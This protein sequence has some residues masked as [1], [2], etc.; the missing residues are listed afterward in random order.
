MAFVEAEQTNGSKEDVDD[1]DMFGEDDE[2]SRPKK[3]RKGVYY[4]PIGMRALLR[5]IRANVSLL[6]A[7]YLRLTVSAGARRST[8]LIV[9]TKSASPAVPLRRLNPLSAR[10]R[11]L[12]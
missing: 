12:K 1:E 4:K 2:D 11:P 3:R 9:G 6:T 7:I 8:R 10:Q 5:K